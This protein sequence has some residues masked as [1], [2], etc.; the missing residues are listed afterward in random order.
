[1]PV[2]DLEG[3][4]TFEEVCGATNASRSHWNFIRVLMGIKTIELWDSM[5]LR[6]SNGKFL[7]AT[8]RYVKDVMAREATEGRLLFG[9]Q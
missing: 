6:A 9:H 1:M 4:Y 2:P 3:S 8:K 7:K 5:G